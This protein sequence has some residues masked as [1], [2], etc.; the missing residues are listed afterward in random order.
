M[1]QAPSD[2]NYDPYWKFT[3]KPVECTRCS[4]IIK[5]GNRY[6]FFPHCGSKFCTADKCGPH[7]VRHILTAH[8][9]IK[10]HPPQSLEFNDPEEYQPGTPVLA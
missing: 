10:E 2:L 1:P 6:F 7:E 3:D 8:T 5:P 4:G 9:R